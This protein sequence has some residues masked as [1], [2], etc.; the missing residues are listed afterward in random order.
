MAWIKAHGKGRVFFSA[1]GH[2]DYSFWNPALLQH[3]LAGIPV[4]AGG[5][6]G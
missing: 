2:Y 6:G 1:F 3:Y 4:C 5:P